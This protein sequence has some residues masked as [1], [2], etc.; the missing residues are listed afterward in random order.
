MNDRTAT[1]LNRG[2]PER[3]CSKQK[4]LIFECIW[5]YILCALRINVIA[6]FVAGRQDMRVQLA[7]GGKSCSKLR[8]LKFIW[9]SFE[10]LLRVI[11]RANLSKPTTLKG[12]DLYFQQ[13][14][15][16]TL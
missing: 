4:Q 7:E 6:Y 1:I 3:Q 16:L 9:L 13:D 8:L 15:F 5:N 10:E 14:K 2:L 11:N 12:G